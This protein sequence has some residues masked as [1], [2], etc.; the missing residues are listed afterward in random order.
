MKRDF[1][2]ITRV[3]GEALDA[4]EPAQV[5]CMLD[6]QKIQ[7]MTRIR[8]LAGRL[9]AAAAVVTDAVARANASEHATGTPLSDFLATSEG[10]TPRE[11][12]G[13]TYRASRIAGNPAVRDAALSGQVSPRH[14]QAIGDQLAHMPTDRMD[15]AQADAAAQAFL[16]QAPA[17]TP[18]RLR[19]HADSILEQVA[20][21]LAPAPDDTAARAALR[22]RRAVANRRFA[23][24]NDTEGSIHF[25]GQVPEIQGMRL[26]PVLDAFVEAGRRDEH[27]QAARLRTQRTSGAITSRQYMEAHHEPDSRGA[28]TTGQRMADAL[29]AMIDALAELGRIPAAG[30]ETPRI[31]VTLDHQALAQAA[32]ALQNGEARRAAALLASAGAINGETGLTAGQLRQLLCDAEI[33]PM[34]LGGQSE[35]LDVGRAARLVTPVL[36]KTLAA[37]DGGCVF[38]GCT[39]P[40]AACQAHH[41]IPW[42]AGGSTSL[43]NL[44]LVCRHHHSLVEPDPAAARDQWRIVFD[45]ATRRPRAIPPERMRGH[46]QTTPRPKRS[47]PGSAPPPAHPGESPSSPRP[48]ENSASI[49]SHSPEQ[50][51][52]TA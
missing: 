20:P 46:L 48:R 26:I 30:G 4:F 52:L 12:L 11:G 31:I 24:W 22:R 2:E 42:W 49:I 27:D 41:V 7:A 3:I 19:R 34:V 25:S 16:G 23:W 15:A 40:S 1:W 32:A 29:M 28:R 35:I 37:R 8:G 38:P 21:D 51:P 47:A 13:E 45:P 17:T 18:G 44:V 6:D 36:R 10:R 39:A 50:Q 5:A 33:L 14:A 9:D 43:D